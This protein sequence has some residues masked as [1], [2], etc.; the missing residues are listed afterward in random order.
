MLLILIVISI[1][2]FRVFFTF[3]IVNILWVFFR[4]DNILHAFKIIKAMFNVKNINLIL[5]TDFENASAGFFH[6]SMIIKILIFS[7]ILAFYS[8]NSFEKLADTKFKSKM[9][10]ETIT[11]LVLGILFLDKVSKFLYFNF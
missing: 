2:I 3:N 8:K 10:I 9:L 1:Y 6:M 5:T 7:L 11:Y 4:A